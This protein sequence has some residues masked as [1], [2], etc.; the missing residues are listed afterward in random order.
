L[1]SQNIVSHVQLP[2]L[3][4]ARSAQQCAFRTADES[5]TT[6]LGAAS[7]LHKHWLAVSWQ[8]VVVG[9][10][11]STGESELPSV[12]PASPPPPSPPSVATETPQGDAH[13]AVTQ[14]FHP[15][16]PMLTAAQ[17][18]LAQ[19]S[20]SPTHA[21]PAL[22]HAFTWTWQLLAMHCP[23]SVDSPWNRQLVPRLS[24][25]ESTRR[26]QLVADTVS[27]RASSRDAVRQ[28]ESRAAMIVTK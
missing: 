14:L 21:A 12:A 6:P 25:A 19:A 3:G 16:V 4:Q 9:T 7:S 8:E 10:V 5:Q 20:T 28:D 2:E 13:I 17:L 27:V 23:H 11:D 26:M 24:S 18:P 22:Q 1:I 15:A